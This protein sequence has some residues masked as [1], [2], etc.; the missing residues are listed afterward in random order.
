MLKIFIVTRVNSLNTNVYLFSLIKEII[1]FSILFIMISGVHLPF[2]MS[3]G[4]DGL[5]HSL[6]IILILLGYFFLNINLM[7]VLFNK[8]FLS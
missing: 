5:C 6:M 2:V 4:L 1:L 3:L 8:N 7:P